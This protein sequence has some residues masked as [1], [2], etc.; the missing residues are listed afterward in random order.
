MSH[1]KKDEEGIPGNKRGQGKRLKLRK[2]VAY[3]GMWRED[4]CERILGTQERK[5][6]KDVWNFY[7]ME[8]GT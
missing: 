1:I 6:Q 8:W 4:T 7:F 2:D 3:G 5:W